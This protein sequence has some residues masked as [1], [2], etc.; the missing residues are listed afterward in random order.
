MAT[1]AAHRSRLSS[2]HRDCHPRRQPG[3]YRT[4]EESRR[5]LTHETYQHSPSLR[6]RAGLQRRSIVSV[7]P[8][9]TDDR[10]HLDEGPTTRFVREI[11]GR[12]RCTR[13]VGARQVGVTK[14]IP[15]CLVPTCSDPCL[16][17]RRRSAACPLAFTLV[18]LLFKLLLRSLLSPLNTP[19]IVP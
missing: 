12:Y 7:L 9:D 17:W 16:V 19:A 13:I 15:R 10:R 1:F 14:S 18:H 5:A 8:N 4:L 2:L 6:L 3:L 11:P